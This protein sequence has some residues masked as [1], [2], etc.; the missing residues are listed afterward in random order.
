[1]QIL[2]IIGTTYELLVRPSI[3][4]FIHLNPLV[5]K[6]RQTYLFMPEPYSYPPEDLACF[7]YTT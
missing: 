6:N 7:P 3:I 4:R 5:R 2:M 1:M